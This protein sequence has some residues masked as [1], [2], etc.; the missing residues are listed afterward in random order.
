MKPFASSVGSP[1]WGFNN[2]QRWL[3]ENFSGHCH[4][5]GSS[6]SGRKMKRTII[7]FHIHF[8]ASLP[9]WPL[10]IPVSAAIGTGWHVLSLFPGSTVVGR[11]S[12]TWGEYGF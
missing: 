3:T 9:S 4:V 11:L 7:V 8:S 12:S 2:V 1:I 6:E 5:L 10:V